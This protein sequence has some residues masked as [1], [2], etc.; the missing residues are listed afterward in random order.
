[1]AGKF[2]NS[3]LCY[4]EKDGCYL[5]LY[6]NKKPDDPCEGKW[7]GVGGKFEPGEDRDTCLLRE[8]REETGLVLT[9]F[10]FRGVVHFVS[11][12]WPDEDMHLYTADGFDGKD[13]FR[14]MDNL[15]GGYEGESGFNPE[16][17]P[18]NTVTD[19]QS[20]SFDCDEGEL[21][22]IPKENVLKL[23]LWEGD[24]YFLQPLLEG[25]EKIEMTCRYEG[26]SCVE[27]HCN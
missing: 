2:I 23:N 21:C 6:R 16:R 10:R 7:V 25:Q 12:T 19:L 5:M 20:E 15:P 22:W 14:H 17:D 9:R 4:I 13:C 3:T 26:H 8:V 27:V 24:K 11:D 18:D 1:M